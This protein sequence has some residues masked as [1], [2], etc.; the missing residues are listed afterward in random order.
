V[1]SV[2]NTSYQ[3]R[4][5]GWKRTGP[6]K[7]QTQRPLSFDSGSRNGGSIRPPVICRWTCTV[8]PRTCSDP[9]FPG[10]LSS[11]FPSS[12]NAPLAVR[13][14]WLMSSSPAIEISG[15]M[16]GGGRWNIA[17]HR[18]TL[19]RFVLISSCF[20]RLQS[21]EDLLSSAGGFGVEA[22]VD[23]VVSEFVQ[24]RR[25]LILIFFQFYFFKLAEVL[26][27]LIRSISITRFNLQLYFWKIRKFW[28]QILFTTTL[29][30]PKTTGL[31][32]IQNY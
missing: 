22:L 3:L 15:E 2:D 17:A 20:N 14:W 19:S 26:Q 29:R 30:I 13:G 23:E 6:S 4:Q 12:S 25:A 28:C 16:S 9:S 18:W 32:L 31:K 5:D 27:H 11:V 10:D 21:R 7:D 1:A 8:N 24:A